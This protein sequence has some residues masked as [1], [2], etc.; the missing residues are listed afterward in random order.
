MQE[1]PSWHSGMNPIRNLE[2]ACSI[3]GLAQWVKD[4]ELQSRLPMRLR[5]WHCCGCGVDQ[6]LSLQLDPSLGTSKYCGCGPK[7]TKINK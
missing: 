3:P 7:K 4:L 6:Q 2:V 5:I 1:F